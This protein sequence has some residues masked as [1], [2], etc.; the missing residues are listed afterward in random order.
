[1][2][3]LREVASAIWT[4]SL[5]ER[6]SLITAKLATETDDAELQMLRRRLAEEEAKLAILEN[7]PFKK[8]RET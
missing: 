7:D 1:V 2:H 3:L 4:N 8:M 5:P 6:T